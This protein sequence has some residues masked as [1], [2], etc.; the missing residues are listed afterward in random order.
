MYSYS[1]KNPETPLVVAHNSYTCHSAVVWDEIICCSVMSTL[2]LNE[3][4]SKFF[5]LSMSVGSVSN[6]MYLDLNIPDMDAYS[7]GDRVGHISKDWSIESPGNWALGR[8]ARGA[9]INFN[10]PCGCSPNCSRQTVATTRDGARWLSGFQCATTDE[11]HECNNSEENFVELHLENGQ[12]ER[13]R[14]SS[15]PTLC[16]RVGVWIEL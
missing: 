8:E 3:Y 12:S 13:Y 5:S 10:R 4:V 14:S 9:R 6:Q 1:T 7:Y 15:R 16:N 11:G 2:T